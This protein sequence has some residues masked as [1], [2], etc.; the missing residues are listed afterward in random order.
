M[1]LGMNAVFMGELEDLSPASTNLVPQKSIILSFRFFFL[2]HFLLFILKK[3]KFFFSRILT[4]KQEKKSLE[5]PNVYMYYT[6]YL[7]KRYLTG[8]V[9]VHFLFS[10]SFLFFCFI[11]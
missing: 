9:G 2:S 10:F 5:H 8:V 6:T 7:N 1:V 11:L 4:V 3:K